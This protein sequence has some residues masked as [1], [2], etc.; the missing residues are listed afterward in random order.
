VTQ[1]NENQRRHIL[2]TCQYIDRLL[3]DFEAIAAGAVSESPFARYADDLTPEQRVIVREHCAELRVH[4]LRVLEALGIATGRSLTSSRHAV[5]SGLG[6]I[7]IALE[8]LKP[9]HMRGYGDMPP[10]VVPQLNGLVSELQGLVHRVEAA[11]LQI[12]GPAEPAPADGVARRRPA[13]ALDWRP[14]EAELGRAA[15]LF[16]DVQAMCDS[17]KEAPDA[18]IHEALELAADKAAKALD[19]PESHPGGVDG[20]VHAAITTVAVDRA[21]DVRRPLANLVAAARAALQ[22]AAHALGEPEAVFTAEWTILLREMPTFSL[23]AVHIE[24]RLVMRKALGSGVAHARMRRTIEAQ[25]GARVTKAVST[26]RQ[27]L[28]SWSGRVLARVRRDFEAASK[29]YRAK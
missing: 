15:G 24:L 25:I 16:D 3:G 23:D 14:V 10:E 27:G 1:L 28:A 29:S 20:A 5:R 4:M 7:D 12:G 8:E 26:Y 22:T 6:F 18:V 19:F 17:L 21:E 2:S 13:G 11:L 9:H